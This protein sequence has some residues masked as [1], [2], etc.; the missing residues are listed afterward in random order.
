MQSLIQSKLCDAYSMYTLNPF[1]VTKRSDNSRCMPNNRNMEVELTLRNRTSFLYI[2]KDKFVLFYE[3]RYNGS[4]Q[5][6]Q[7]FGWFCR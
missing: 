4:Q 2:L 3:L 5:G 1:Q 6:V 7:I